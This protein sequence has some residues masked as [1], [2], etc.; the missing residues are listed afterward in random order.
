MLWHGWNRNEWI[1]IITAPA[2]EKIEAFSGNKMF[3]HRVSSSFFQAP[4]PALRWSVESR[5]L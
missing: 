2:G 4:E 3:Q 1:E 5:V